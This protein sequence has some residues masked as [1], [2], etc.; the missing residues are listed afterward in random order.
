MSRGPIRQDPPTE[1]EKELRDLVLQLTALHMQ[2]TELLRAAGFLPAYEAE[3]LVDE[4]D[5][6]T[7]MDELADRFFDGD[8]RKSRILLARMLINSLYRDQ[9]V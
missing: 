7:F 6:N 4:F 5:P 8:T 2:Q 1:R 3:G 9:D